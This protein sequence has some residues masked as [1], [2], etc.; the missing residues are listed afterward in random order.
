ML[1]VFSRIIILLI[2]WITPAEQAYPVSILGQE[3]DAYKPLGISDTQFSTLGSK[4]DI[5]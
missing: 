4:V 1:L 5:Q 2:Y 3:N